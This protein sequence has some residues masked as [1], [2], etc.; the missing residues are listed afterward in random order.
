LDS[1]GKVPIAQLPSSIMEYKGTWNAATNTP[2][3]AN[4]TGDTGDVYICNV[5]GTVNFGAGP[6]TFAVGDYVIYSGTIWQRS[7]GAVGTVTSV[8]L[9]SA[10]SGVTIGSTPITTSGTITLAIATA[11]GSAQGLLSSTDW[12]TFNSKQNALTNP[13]TG[14]GASGQVTFFNG[15]S[16]V[17][18]S[19]NHFWDATNN[20]LGIGLVNPQRSIEIFNSTA[21]NH[22]RLSGNAPSVSMG[23]AVTG[24]IYQAKFGL[25]TVNGQF[26]TA[27]VAGDFVIISQTGATIIGTSSTEKMRVQSSG[28]VSINNTNDT[29]KLDVTG[30]A[31]LTGQLRLESTITDGT[32]TYT[33][34]SATG[35]LALTSALSGYL[36][37]TGGTLTGA[38]TVTNGRIN[39]NGNSSD[40]KAIMA[41]GDAT[42][43]TATIGAFNTGG[44]VLIAGQSGTGM[45]IGTTGA[46]TF[47]SSVTVNGN[48]VY[49]NGGQPETRYA[50]NDVGALP[51]GLWRTVLGGDAFYVQKNTAVAGDFSTAINCLQFINTGAATFS[52]SV[53]VGDFFRLTKASS[54]DIQ[55]YTGAAYTN[56]NYDAASHNWQTSG[57]TA[58]MVLTSAG[59]VG[60]GTTSP[61]NI[62]TINKGASSGYIQLIGLSRNLYLGQ[63][64]TGAAIY[65]DGDAPMY[66]ST[67]ATEKMRITSGGNV[68][69]GTTSPSVA[70][71]VDASGG[72]IIRATRLGAGSAY[73]QLEADG[74]N[75]TLTSSAA[76][77]MNAGGSERT[78]ITSGGNVL[79][80]TTSDTGQKL[81]VS[82]NIN[83]NGLATTTG[84]TANSYYMPIYLDNNLYYLPL[85]G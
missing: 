23:E 78:R 55:A 29:F 41:L 14:T 48:I 12:T 83:I 9:S 13:V 11:S 66:F 53:S 2:T 25:V 60:I 80:G 19:N 28:N 54:V 84:K 71:Q 73:V 5:A 52:S 82:G 18:G 61:G 44:T 37:L 51:L 70:L 45:T 77:I 35:T 1:A 43:P 32:N 7:S 24:S 57:G 4:G 27:G 50:E 22:L 63:D 79:I 20:R 47:S 62:L 31:R 72:G 49:I 6:I 36:P 34:P 39:L 68:G 56:L 15:T 67:N 65:S 33:L 38:L 26:V 21:D 74:T 10:T 42:Y 17:T 59:L 40:G 64:S 69:I 3:L 46:A 30:T 58:K 16:T 8:G 81:I 85:Y 75:G 76:L